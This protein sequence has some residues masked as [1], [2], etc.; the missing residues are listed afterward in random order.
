MDIKEVAMNAVS[1]YLESL[2][3]T[4]YAESRAD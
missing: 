1:S 4:A 2:G 3:M